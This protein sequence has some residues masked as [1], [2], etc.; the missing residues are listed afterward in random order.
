MVI[1]MKALKQIVN[2]DRSYLL[3]LYTAEYGWYMLPCW[4]AIDNRC[5]CPKGADCTAKAKH[6]R[7]YSG[8]TGAS[9]DH[10]QILEWHTQFPTCNWGVVHDKSNMVA[11]DNDPRNGGNE[12]VW[13]LEKKY[14]PLP[15]TKTQLTGG[16]GWH[17]L[18]TLSAKCRRIV[19]TLGP[20]IDVKHHGY[21]IIAP[22]NHTSG[23]SYRWDMEAPSYLVE[24]PEYLYA[25]PQNTSTTF[26]Q[27]RVIPAGERD[28]TLTSVAGSLRGHGC[29]AVEILTSLT[30][31]NEARCTPELP[32]ADL[33]RIANSV[34]RYPSNVKPKIQWGR[35]SEVPV[36]TVKWLWPCRIPF[37]MLTVFEGDPGLG[38]SM[39]TMDLVARVT[40]GSPMP[41]SDVVPVAPMNA[42]IVNCEDGMSN[43]V[44]PRLEA[45]GGDCARVVYAKTKVTPIA[46]PENLGEL[47]AAIV[48]NEVKLLVIDPWTAFLGQGIN[49][50]ND[51]SLREILTPLSAIA[52]RTSCAIILVRHLNKDTKQNSMYRGSGSI[53]TT[54]AARC[55]IA[56]IKDPEDDTARLIAA[57]KN[58]LA[59]PQPTS[60]FVLTEGAW[61]TIDWTGEVETTADQAYAGGANVEKPTV[62]A[63]KYISHNINETYSCVKITAEVDTGPHVF[64]G[65]CSSPA[66]LKRVHFAL[67]ALGCNK[68]KLDWQNGIFELNGLGDREAKATL[69]WNAKHENFEIGYFYEVGK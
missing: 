53:A 42:M 26:S 23:G 14:G 20:G 30:A 40:S 68:P 25:R 12:T 15:P 45:M 1:T 32:K 43:T 51:A 16:G 57:V 62:Y 49:M 33:A 3:E 39:V 66:G 34:Q 61:P 58:N 24:A 6:P 27:L 54:A 9:N 37:G 8:Q 59:K 22:S 56:I 17:K 11:V 31:I 21:S 50:N 47:E 7:L 36:E 64:Y 63:A 48:E 67:K 19:S 2:T 13:D 18:Y 29:G 69:N 44:R 38:K 4:H 46:F 65:Y 41:F 55:G 10:N 35:L 60:R 28:N 5:A 52:E